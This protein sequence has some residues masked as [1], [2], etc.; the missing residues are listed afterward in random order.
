MDGG[1]DDDAEWRGWD[2][3]KA[4]EKQ[5]AGREDLPGMDE[6]MN[7]VAG[8]NRETSRWDRIFY[9]T[10]NRSLGVFFVLLP[11]GADPFFSS[12]DLRI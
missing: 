9:Y 6:L 5:M 10:E 3:P 4:N 8:W 7:E 2:K 11:I 1:A 12:F